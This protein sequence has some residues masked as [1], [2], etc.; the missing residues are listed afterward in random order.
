MN[1]YLHVTTWEPH[2]ACGDLQALDIFDFSDVAILRSRSC[3]LEV[4]SAWHVPVAVIQ[5]VCEC[6]NDNSTSTVLR[7]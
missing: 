6:E 5:V 2:E 3:E 7:R 1:S 4:S